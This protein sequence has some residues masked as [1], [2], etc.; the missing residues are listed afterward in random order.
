MREILV[1]FF[2]LAGAVFS[3]L[4]T[5]GITRMPDFLTR[6]Q[7]STKAGTLGVVC[8]LAGVAVWFTDFGVTV[9]AGLVIVFLFATAPVAAHLLSRAAYIRG[10]PLWKGTIRDDLE[11]Q[12]DIDSHAL[13]SKPRGV[14][15]TDTEWLSDTLIDEPR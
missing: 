3:L 5:I 13:A 11:G 1:T 2:L 8:L 10:V 9:R 12:Y 4:G 6:M 15:P 14:G 7:A